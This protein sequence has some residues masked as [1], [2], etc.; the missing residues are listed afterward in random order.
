MIGCKSI[1]ISQD[2]LAHRLGVSRT[3]INKTLGQL[4]ESNLISTHYRQSKTCEYYFPE[5]F[6]QEDIRKSLNVFLSNFMKFSIFLLLSKPAANQHPT[7]LNIKENIVSL[8]RNNEAT[9]AGARARVRREL[10]VNKDQKSRENSVSDNDYYATVTNAPN[11]PLNQS[12]EK[13]KNFSEWI[14]SHEQLVVLS[15]FPK[16]AIQEASRAYAHALH[17][18]EVIRDKF[19]YFLSVCKRWKKKCEDKSNLRN[20]Q[21][22][23]TRKAW[24]KEGPLSLWKGFPERGNETAQQTLESFKSKMP[25]DNPFAALVLKVI[26]NRAKL[27]GSGND[28]YATSGQIETA[29]DMRGIK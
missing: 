16:E 4:R 19:S 9:N 27:E 20:S 18:G 11:V 12:F 8:F 3:T 25:H 15:E 2:T 22:N 23:T 5:L 17:R 28:C 6:K 7:Q 21:A 26:E 13:N 29:P 10:G 1:Y 14:F 24:A